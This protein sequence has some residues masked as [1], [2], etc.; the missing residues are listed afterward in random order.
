M[1]QIEIERDKNISLVDLFIDN[2]KNK[3]K[4]NVYIKREYLK[5]NRE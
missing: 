1:G 2:L 4:M 3:M 5:Y